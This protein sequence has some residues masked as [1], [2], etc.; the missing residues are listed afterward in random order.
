MV[1]LPTESDARSYMV[2]DIEPNSAAS[3]VLQSVLESDEEHGKRNNTLLQRGFKG[4][5]FLKILPAVAPHN[6]RQHNIRV[7]FCDEVDGYEVT[8]EGSATLLA[9][10]RTMSYPNRKIVLGSTPKDKDTSTIIAAYAESD[11][12][13]F[14]CPCPLCGGFTELKWKHIVWPKDHL[15]EAKF[16]CPHCESLIDERYKAQMMLIVVTRACVKVLKVIGFSLTVDRI[17]GSGIDDES[18]RSL[19]HD[20]HASVGGGPKV[21]IRFANLSPVLNTLYTRNGS[22]AIAAGCGI[23]ALGSGCTD[24]DGGDRHD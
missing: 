19:P 21:E 9:I 24:Q 11:Q 5:H 22:N 4:G 12:R 2:S 8:S 3:P 20:L 1:L 23:A 16:K 13:V 15:E 17:S 14:E 10:G 18:V 6:L 7:L